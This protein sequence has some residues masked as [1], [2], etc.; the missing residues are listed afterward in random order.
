MKAPLKKWVSLGA[1]SNRPAVYITP[2]TMKDGTSL[3]FYLTSG[4]AVEA[5]SPHLA[6]GLN[7]NVIDLSDLNDEGNEL[8][9]AFEKKAA[10][11]KQWVLVDFINNYNLYM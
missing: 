3:Y 7:K 1:T 9:R 4:T 10:Y 6:F 11:H 2:I 8:V 5:V